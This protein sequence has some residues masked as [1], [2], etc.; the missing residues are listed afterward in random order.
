MNRRLWR[1]IAGSA[2]TLAVV[3]ACWLLA[4]LAADRLGRKELVSALRAQQQMTRAVVGNMT[5]VIAS[6]LNMARA[7]PATMAETDIVEQALVQGANYDANRYP[8]EQ[9]RRAALQ[10]APQFVHANQLLRDAQGF[11]GL[12]AIWLVNPAGICI[13][14]SNA[15]EPASYVGV[16]MSARPYLSATRLGGFAELYGVS[17]TNGDP[18]IFVAAPVYHDGLLIGTIAARVGLSRLRHWVAH[19][20]TF[21][22]DHNG[23][24]VMAHDSA[25]QGLALPDSPVE[26]MAPAERTATY[27]RDHFPTI[28]IAPAAASI[29]QQ[30]PWVPQHTADSLVSLPNQPGPAF[31]EW[32]DGLNSGLSAHLVDPLNVWPDVLANHRR[33]RLLIFV[34]LAGSFALTA[35]VATWWIRERRLHRATRELADQ[36]QT[37]NALLAAEARDDALTGALSRRYFLDLLRHEIDHAHETGAPLCLAL[38]D[39]DHFKQVND[40]FGHP[41]GDHALQHFVDTCRAE[42]RAGDV[43]GRLGGE[44]FGILMPATSLAAGFEVAERL[45]TQ[46][47][48]RHCA[49][50]PDDVLLSASIG[51]TGLAAGQDTV[52]RLMSRADLALYT[53]KEAGRD[54]CAAVS[55]D[56]AGVPPRSPERAS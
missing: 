24:I 38:A 9:A 23:V 13:A 37:A 10:G 40:R 31:H 1:Q 47:H 42:L 7:V 36:L 45:R 41:A 20:G 2:G 11:S 8:T 55:P 49:T 34:T 5:E 18:G 29:R 16:D 26:R 30:A 46:F 51:I 3:L 48:S 39:L 56:D 21:V 6:D 35:V 14:S 33:N 12:D 44:E 27:L 19:P 50:L 15:N 52:E 25:L 54:R 43:V 22:S 32:R 17:P 53:A 4:G 28:S